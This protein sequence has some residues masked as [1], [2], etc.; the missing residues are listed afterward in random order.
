MYGFPLVVVMIC[1]FNFAM[2]LRSFIYVLILWILCYP[3]ALCFTDLFYWIVVRIFYIILE[4]VPLICILICT[5]CTSRY[6]EIFVRKRNIRVNK[7][8]I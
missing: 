2:N 4:V 1:Y 7:N 5:Q 6:M 8:T 3:F